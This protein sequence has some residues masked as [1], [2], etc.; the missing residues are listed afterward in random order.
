MSIEH[1]NS[2]QWLQGQASAMTQSERAAGKQRFRLAA[3]HGASGGGR[4]LWEALKQRFAQA[5]Q[6]S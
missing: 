5:R 2:K 1:Y 4:A 3:L 6:A